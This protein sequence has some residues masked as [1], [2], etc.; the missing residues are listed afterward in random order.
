MLKSMHTFFLIAIETE[1]SKNNNLFKPN[2]DPNLK[3]KTKIL[4][5]K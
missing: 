5:K 1:K 4:V 3:Y 2:L